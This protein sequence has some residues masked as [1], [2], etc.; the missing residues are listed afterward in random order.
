MREIANEMQICSALIAMGH[1]LVLGQ[2]HMITFCAAYNI[3]S[4]LS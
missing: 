1:S 2:Y 4:I 3:G